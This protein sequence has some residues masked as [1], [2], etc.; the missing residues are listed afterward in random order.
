METQPMWLGLGDAVPLIPAAPPCV[1]ILIHW[2]KA[3]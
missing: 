1:R 2:T 3:S